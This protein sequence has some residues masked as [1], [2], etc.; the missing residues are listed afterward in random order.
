MHRLCTTSGLL[1]AR[2]L[3]ASSLLGAGL[4][5]TNCGLVD[6][7]D[8][9][10]QL[11]KVRGGIEENA[12]TPRSQVPWR[13]SA[14]P[15]CIPQQR[16]MA[17]LS[18]K[19]S[20]YCLGDSKDMPVD[21]AG[22]IVPWSREVARKQMVKMAPL[23]VLGPGCVARSVPHIILTTS[24]AVGDRLALP[25]RQQGQLCSHSRS[26]FAQNRPSLRPRH[27]G[28]CVGLSAAKLRVN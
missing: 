2:R 18:S 22:A 26:S 23:W 4:E 27:Q 14:C 6:S 12:G 15:P 19:I 9:W 20:Y 28:R 10:S 16:H 7:D 17:H 1:V 5:I 13:A 8:K 21:I 25:C 24:F 3:R 11:L